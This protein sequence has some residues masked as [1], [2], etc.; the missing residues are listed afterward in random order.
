[1]FIKISKEKS[2]KPEYVE[3]LRNLIIAYNSKKSLK[4]ISIKM[5]FKEYFAKKDFSIK[6]DTVKIALQKRLFPDK[7]KLI[8]PILFD[9]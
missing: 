7:P 6:D 2:Y 3:F 8:F 5:I 9:T 4:K 1:M